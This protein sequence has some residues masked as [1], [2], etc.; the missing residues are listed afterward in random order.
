METGQ[1]L[2]SKLPVDF[3]NTITA[4][5]PHETQLTDC[6]ESKRPFGYKFLSVHILGLYATGIVHTGCWPVQNFNALCTRGSL[7]GEEARTLTLD[8]Y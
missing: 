2:L 8:G 5:V 6:N 4:F 7:A 1:M 3:K